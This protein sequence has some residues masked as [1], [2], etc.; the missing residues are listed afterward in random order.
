MNFVE[1]G[2]CLFIRLLCCYAPCDDV[3]V[4]GFVER[5]RY[6]TV[7]ELFEHCKKDH[8]QCFICKGKGILNQY[9]KDYPMLES[10]FDSHYK[11]K[12]RECLERKFVVFENDIDLVAHQV[13]FVNL[14]FIF[15]LFSYSWSAM[16]I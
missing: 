14:L 1:Q 16:Q 10:H 2:I 12:E 8:E 6:Y 13:F 7:D 15:H 11:C 4:T 5:A 9:Y 3:V